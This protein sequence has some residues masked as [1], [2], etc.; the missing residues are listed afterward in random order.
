MS[1]LP[2]DPD[3][4][5]VSDLRALEVEAEDDVV[6]V[7][8][9]EPILAGRGFA[10]LILILALPFVQPIPIP[11]LSV[12]FGIAIIA[13][14]LRLALGSVAGLPRF[15]KRREIDAGTF[16]KLLAGARRVFAK[17]ERFFARR[18][19]VLLR[20][21]L[22]NLA[23]VSLMASGLAMCLP[24]P[25]VIL[26]SNSLPAIAAILICLGLIERDGLFVAAGHAVAVATWVYFAFWWE[27]VKLT[28][29]HL[30]AQLAT[31]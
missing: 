28:F 3:E 25:P 19:T 31:L 8:D 20:P 27:V 30:V 18:L 14:G 17:L 2:N 24:L 10:T 15:V 23:G 29:Q 12:P 1:R 6:R 22:L 13:L 7:G 21:P 11:G 9:I 5:F 4:G 26:F 16:R